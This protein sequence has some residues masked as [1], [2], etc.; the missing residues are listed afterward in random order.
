M[1]DAPLLLVNHWLTVDPPSPAVAERVNSWS[2]LDA[3]V[4]ECEDVRHRHPN[5]I[6]VDF[7]DRGD[8]F[9]FVDSLNGLTA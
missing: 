8:V 6:A 9:A 7:Y 1:P 4:S 3:R 2:A 5:I